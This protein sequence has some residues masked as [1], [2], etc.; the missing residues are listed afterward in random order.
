MTK[1][2][3]FEEVEDLVRSWMCQLLEI[4]EDSSAV[5]LSYQDD[6][7][8]S[9]DYDDTVLFIRLSET[10]DPYGHQ[11]SDI[12]YIQGNDVIKQSSRTR[13]WEL[14][15]ICYGPCA[16][17]WLNRIKDG[18]FSQLSK[19]LCFREDVAI[20]PTHPMIQRVPELYNGRWWK[21]FDLKLTM[22]ELYVFEENVRS[23]DDVDVRTS[24]G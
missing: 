20:L 12:H 6:G 17:E 5:R 21:R 15:F 2:R 23:I 7:A 3:T 18:V 24:K 14:Y 11:R 13:V 22:N 16:S 19:A 10:D 8:P 1:T 4:D 9:W